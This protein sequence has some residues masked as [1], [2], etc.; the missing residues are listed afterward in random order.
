M[1]TEV[2]S[3]QECGGKCLTIGFLKK[4]PQFVVFAPSSGLNI[5]T[6]AGSKVPK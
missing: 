2:T 4:M 3:A 1:M 5:L 6:M